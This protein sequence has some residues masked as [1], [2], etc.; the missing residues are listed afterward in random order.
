MYC[1]IFINEILFYEKKNSTEL[2]SL[3]IFGQQLI[4]V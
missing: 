3:F 1:S 2:F 4:L